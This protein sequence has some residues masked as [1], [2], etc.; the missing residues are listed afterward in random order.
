MDYCKT[1]DN[2][3]YTLLFTCANP[4]I[5]EEVYHCLK[6]YF[7]QNCIVELFPQE[8]CGGGGYI[9]DVGSIVMDRFA[10]TGW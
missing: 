5:Y 3:K 8:K 6:D 2:S 10:A 9:P 7:P 1:L 4:D